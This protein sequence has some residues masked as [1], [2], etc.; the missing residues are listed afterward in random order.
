MAPVRFGVAARLFAG[1]AAMALIAGGI[2]LIAARA[3]STASERLDEVALTRLPATAQAGL[4]GRQSQALADTIP[5]L[6]F[7]TTQ[8]DRRT[9][10]LRLDDT[11]AW[12]DDELA[13]LRS[14][15]VPDRRL[16]TVV[17]P[18]RAVLESMRGL[19]GLVAARIEADY[20]VSRFAL[21]VQQADAQVRLLRPALMG[22]R[23]AADWALAASATLNTLAA[24]AGEPH[25]ARVRAR[26]GDYRTRLREADAAF[27]R[28]PPALAAQV[29]P[30]QE[31]L[32]AIGGGVDQGTAAPPEGVAA[33]DIFGAREASLTAQ[34]QVRARLTQTGDVSNQFLA[35]VWGLVQYLQDEAASASRQTRAAQ[36]GDLLLVALLTLAAGAT[37]GGLLVYLNRSVLR[38][39]H[40]LRDAMAAE[41]EGRPAPLPVEGHDEIATM[42]R[43]LARLRDAIHGREEALQASREQARQ[44]AETAPVALVVTRIPDRRILSIN[45]RA[46]EMFEISREEAL[47]Q[48]A[49]PFYAVPGDRHAWQQAL[50]RDGVARD[51]VVRMQTYNGR[52]FTAMLSAT[53]SVHEG[54]LAWLVALVD[55]TQRLR[56]EESLRTA[57]NQ[58]EATARELVRSN[59][60]L[61]Q[62]AYVAS[63]DLREPLR[64]VAS[65][66]N[67][68]ERRY[69]DQLNPQAR[70]FIAFAR[71][72]VERMEH[73]IQDL[74][75]YS[76]AGRGIPATDPVP[77]DAVVNEAL[78]NLDAAVRRSEG[79]IR[80][81]A[82]LPAVR[83]DRSDLLRLFQNLIG[84]A[85]KYRHPERAPDIRIG[86]L[87]RPEGGLTISVADN[88]IGI[89]P[90]HFERIFLIFQRLHGRNAYEGT[91]IGLAICRKVVERLG[92]SIRLDSAE[93]I[94]TTFHIDL[95][96]EAVEPA[97][98]A[99]GGEA[100]EARAEG[101]GLTR[102]GP[103]TGERRA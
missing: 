8:S 26:R 51:F 63:H 98:P 96:A 75:E 22:E 91:G 82:A 19:D 31:Q 18:Y 61:E 41:A 15:G 5:F 94:G 80:I 101:D 50:Y 25:E 24:A 16:A 52:R 53:K 43:S 67:L 90:A 71:S 103:G 27:A 38:R 70:E 28:L 1:L 93:G 6:V 102:S 60:D 54:Q 99:A 35:A 42:A 46:C 36:G 76:R 95:P 12:L 44:I 56:T 64:T 20:L 10:A 84:N 92:G 55:I 34:R 45:Q 57:K 9:V 73:L 11:A 49:D 7:S 89:A 97:G 29:Q 21:Q 83:G 79:T 88:G 58:A 17:T 13:N 48:T 23:G 85:L 74:L 39:L 78:V 47:A 40:Q 100:I 66:V 14:A 65:Y 4:I 62:F 68:L 30:V 77:L 59:A 69:T 87:P 81:E 86:C 33:A 72:G 37:A 3:L 2:A 32:H